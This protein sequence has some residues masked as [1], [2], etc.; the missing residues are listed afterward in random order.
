MLADI[1]SPVEPKNFWG[2][3]AFGAWDASTQFANNWTW[4]FGIPV[5]AAAA[6]AVFWGVAESDDWQWAFLISLFSGTAAFAFT[7]CAFF[8]VCFFRAGPEIYYLERVSADILRE[9]LKPKIGIYVEST[10]H[11]V[12][13]EETW[14][15]G[16]N[17][18]GPLSMWVQ[19][20]VKPTS[21]VPLDDCEARLIRVTRLDEENDQAVLEEPVLCLWSNTDKTSI[22]IPVGVAYHANMFAIFSNNKILFPVTLP[23]K[24]GFEKQIRLPGL[25]RLEVSVSARD[26]PTRTVRFLF[27]WDGRPENL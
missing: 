17:A 11:G 2:R 9:R 22:K 3:C 1:L 7:W 20:A 27:T 25:F 13:R 6:A 15:F 16:A 5:L 19:F 4:L 18:A 21:D 14:D 24:V 23:R 10:N 26:V 12:H 8:A